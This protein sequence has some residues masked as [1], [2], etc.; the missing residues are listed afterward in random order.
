MVDAGTS[1]NDVPWSW[2]HFFEH[3]AQA[4]HRL[5]VFDGSDHEVWEIRGDGL[6]FDPV[7]W[8]GPD[9]PLWR[10]PLR[11]RLIGRV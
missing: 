5:S 10:I 2:E 11:C 3:A 8:S 1:A 9:L 4:K 6:W 7:R